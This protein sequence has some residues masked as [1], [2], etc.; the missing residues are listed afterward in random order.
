MENTNTVID[1]DCK[2]GICMDC[3]DSL[4]IPTSWGLCIPCSRTSWAKHEKEVDEKFPFIII[5]GNGQEID[6]FA[7]E[8][9]ADEY[10]DNI[11]NAKIEV[12]ISE[13][14]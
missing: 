3:G 11:R 10:L 9:E 4:I 1:P 6:R 12:K 7:T 5:G 2:Q 8:P 14:Q 13:R